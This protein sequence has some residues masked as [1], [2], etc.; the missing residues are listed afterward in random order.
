MVIPHFTRF[1]RTAIAAVSAFTLLA[2]GAIVAQASS[3]PQ[4]WTVRVGA[5]SANQAIQ[6][7]AY[8]PGDVYIHAGD[9]VHWVANSAEPHTVTFLAPGQTLP[10]FNPGDP[11]QLFRTGGEVYDPAS[12]FNSGILATVEDSLPIL[13]D[14]S[15]TFPDAGTFDYWCLIHGTMQHGI[16]HV[17]SADEPLPYTQ[18]DYD[19]AAQQSTHEMVV[20]GN[21]LQGQ[22]MRNADGHTVIMGADDGVAMVMRFLRPTLVVHVGESVTFLNDGMGAPHTVTFGEEPANFAIPVGDPA[23]YTGGDLNSGIVPPFGGEY[24]VTFNAAGT[25]TYV[26]ALHDYMGMVGKIIVRP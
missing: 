10:A 23:N 3:Q 12:Y 20:D 21:A 13:P 4:T 16:V 11:A 22:A 1:M 8:L 19:R 24:T 26:C 18:V 17:L 14:Y 6:G 9:T 25:F 7:M 5:Q 2:G 15:L